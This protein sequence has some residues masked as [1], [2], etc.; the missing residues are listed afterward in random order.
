MT[1]PYRKV[2]EAPTSHSA[3]LRFYKQL[4][5]SV[6]I[7]YEVECD[8]VPYQKGNARLLVPEDRH[9][10]ALDWMDDDQIDE[11]RRLAD[12]TEA[13]AWRLTTHPR[14]L[15]ILVHPLTRRPITGSEDDP[16][17]SILCYLDE[18]AAVSASKELFEDENIPS[19]VV[20]I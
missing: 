13:E 12:L 20:R 1:S 7:P 16:G 9:L 5:D 11:T 17:G 15:W 19:V 2:F 14:K 8:S 6:G 10:D 3:K 4:F 18:G